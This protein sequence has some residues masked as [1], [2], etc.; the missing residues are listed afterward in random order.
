M[1]LQCSMKLRWPMAD[2][3]RSIIPGPMASVGKIGSRLFPSI[4]NKDA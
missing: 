2:P 4:P 3:S 1:V